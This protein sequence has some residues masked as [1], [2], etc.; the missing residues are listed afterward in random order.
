[1]WWQRPGFPTRNQKN[2]DR[3]RKAGT[4]ESSSPNE[5]LVSCLGAQR[6]D[7]AASLLDRWDA[8]ARSSLFTLMRK[9]WAPLRK[10]PQFWA[11]MQ[12]EGL[13]KYWHDSGQ[14]PDFCNNEPVCQ[15]R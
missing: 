12:R 1:M 3:I 14:W 13:F 11:L 9:Q 4:Q 2:A 7:D 6:W 15:Q 8:S 5:Y 10:T